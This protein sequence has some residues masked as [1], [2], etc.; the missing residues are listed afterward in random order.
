MMALAAACVKP[1]NDGNACFQSTECHGGSVCAATVYGNYCMKRCD[2]DTVRC[3][4]D[5]EACLLSSDIGVGGTGGEAG[6][7]G[8]GGA[9]GTGGSSMDIDAGPVDPEAGE[10]WV[11][12]P[13]RLENPDYFPRVRGQVCDY[14]IDCGVGLVCVC[15]EGATC[16]GQGKDGPTCEELCDPDVVSLICPDQRPCIDLGT[17]RGYCEP[18]SSE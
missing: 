2:V 11:C 9:A 10:I 8:V 12:L 6:F 17:G 5:F 18:L 13:G 1:I 7:G 4:P 16:S 15:T 14:S 3:E